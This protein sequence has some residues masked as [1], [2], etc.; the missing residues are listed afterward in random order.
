MKV[1]STILFTILPPRPLFFFNEYQNII[2]TLIN[3]KK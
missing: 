3:H 1:V 2:F